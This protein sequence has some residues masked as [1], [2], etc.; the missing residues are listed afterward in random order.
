MHYIYILYSPVIG[1]YFVG[2][3]SN[4]GKNL[5]RHN[6]GKNKRTKSGIP[7]NLVCTEG[8]KTREE[9]VKKEKL[10]KSSESRQELIGFIKKM[11]GKPFT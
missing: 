2:S 3:A 11:N 5:D 7:W 8:F 9:A 1:R 6:S 10:I 4:P